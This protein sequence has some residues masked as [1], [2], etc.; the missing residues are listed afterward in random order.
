[1][2]TLV[3]HIKVATALENEANLLIRMK[4]LLKEM[5]DL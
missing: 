4:M 1:M 3:L 5:F 2:L